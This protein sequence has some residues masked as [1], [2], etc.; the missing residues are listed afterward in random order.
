[1][2]IY[3]HIIR[4]GNGS[5]GGGTGGGQME[6]PARLRDLPVCVSEI[7][8]RRDGGREGGRKGRRDGEMKRGWNERNEGEKR[9]G[10]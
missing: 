6:L 5:E 10:G 8:G 9:E 2:Y 1:M 4:E 7:E 3:T